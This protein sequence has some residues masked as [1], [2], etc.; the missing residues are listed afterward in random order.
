[1]YINGFG[2]YVPEKTLDNNELS[3]MVDTTDEWIVSRTG[4][5]ARHLAAKGQTCSDMVVE[6]ARAALEASG[7]SSCL[8]SHIIVCTVSGDAAFPSTACFAQEKL[9]IPRAM[10]FDLG[11]ACS[12][13][14]YGLRV[15]QGILA[16]E[17]E[18][19]VLLVGAE[20]LS[21]LVNWQDR[22][23]CVL[24]GD[25]AGAVV[26]SNTAADA[27]ADKPLSANAAVEGVLCEGNGKGS[28][29]LY[30]IGG[31]GLSA[32]GPGDIVGTDFFIHMNG[33]EIFKHAVRCMSSSALRLMEKLGC[34]VDEIDLVV[35]HQANLRII[36]GVLD[37]L[38]APESKAFLNLDKYGNTSAAS[39]PMALAEAAAQGVIRAGDRVLLT[40]FGAGLTWGAAVVKFC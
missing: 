12:G 16:V 2:F 14:L 31:G 21:H 8:V 5:K 40:T 3:T 29:L 22:A 6:A 39:I 33:Q 18:S 11:A 15:A 28:E 38:G 25:G 10:A 26:L 32:Y 23:T 20:A 19:V 27:V 7:V 34:P 13:F 9:G 37:R 30:C 1:M 35:P 4:I 17:P 36:K 24:F